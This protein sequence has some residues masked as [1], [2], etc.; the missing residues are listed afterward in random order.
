MRRGDREGRRGAE[1]WVGQE[2]HRVG[3]RSRVRL[4]FGAEDKADR[5][6]DMAGEDL[7]HCVVP[8]SNTETTLANQGVIA[9][10]TQ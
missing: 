1:E 3:G 6:K 10:D 7:E 9:L 4:D 5:F 8:M 2:Y